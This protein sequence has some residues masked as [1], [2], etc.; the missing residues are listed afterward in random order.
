LATVAAQIS[1][2]V[3]LSELLGEWVVAIV[4]KRGNSYTR[5]FLDKAFAESFAEGQRVRLGIRTAL[6]VALVT[7]ADC[8]STPTVRSR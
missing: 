5:S 1:P 3:Q 6:A 8:L 7:E 4:E 2:N